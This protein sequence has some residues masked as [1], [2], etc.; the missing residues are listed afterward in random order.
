MEF[1][2]FRVK[3]EKEA[4]E[5]LKELY[6]ELDFAPTPLHFD[7]EGYLVCQETVERKK[8]FLSGLFGRSEE[9]QQPPTTGIE[10]HTDGSIEIYEADN[11]TFLRILVYD[12]DEDLI[13]DNIELADKIKEYEIRR[14]REDK[15]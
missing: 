3:D 1:E 15:L 5:L 7:E 9:Y 12:E 4:L 13:E 8:G 6:R 10:E 14:I 11:K 2:R